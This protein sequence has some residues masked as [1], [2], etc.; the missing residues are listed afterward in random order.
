MLRDKH[1]H[2]TV[3]QFL[4]RSINKQAPTLPR[5]DPEH[6]VVEHEPNTSTADRHLRW[7]SADRFTSISPSLQNGISRLTE[8]LETN[9]PMGL[10]RLKSPKQG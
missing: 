8:Q 10:K 9:S 6:E 3:V 1:K 5:V 2:N 7:F 4:L